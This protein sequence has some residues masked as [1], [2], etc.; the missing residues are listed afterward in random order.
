VADFVAETNWLE[1]EV[2]SQVDRVV[3][4]RSRW[5]ALEGLAVGQHR[6]GERVVAGFRPEAVEFRVG[7]TNSIGTVIRRVTYLGDSEQYELAGDDGWVL[8]AV[9]PNPGA[10]RR[11]GE[12]VPVYVPPVQLMVLARDDVAAT[13]GTR[14]ER[15]TQT[16]REG[17]P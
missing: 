2:V 12:A 6:V 3:Q 10:G 4:M 5:G 11:V 8:R 13:P 1:A 15:I 7:E 17:V 14:G 9:Q 16:L